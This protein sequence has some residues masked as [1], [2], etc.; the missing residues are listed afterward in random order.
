MP[1]MSDVNKPE[2]VS[3]ATHEEEP[4]I[5]QEMLDNWVVIW[6]PILG[7]DHWR[8]VIELRDDMDNLRGQSKRDGNYPSGLI[9][10]SSTA[11]EGEWARLDD[12]EEL[13]VHELLHFVG[14]DPR[15]AMRDATFLLDK[16]TRKIM[17]R[18][19][20]D[21]NETF[22]ETMARVLVALRHGRADLGIGTL[23]RG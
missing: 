5:T 13:V 8:I 19:F 11:H 2:S 4:V 9:H 7:L 10:I 14:R 20:E 1:Y 17:W 22:V 6:K 23:P 3:I 12:Y 18:R 15:Q 21:A 16:P